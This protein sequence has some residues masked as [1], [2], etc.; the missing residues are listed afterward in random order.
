MSGE[1][2]RR[3]PAADDPPEALPLP[4]DAEPGGLEDAACPAF[5]GGVIALVYQLQA[6]FQQHRAEAQEFRQASIRDR[7]EM[8]RMLEQHCRDEQP[9]LSAIQTRLNTALALVLAVGLFALAGPEGLRQVGDAVSRGG[10]L[11]VDGLVTLAGAA[12]PL[13]YPVGRLIF[14]RLDNGRPSARPP[15]SEERT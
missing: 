7:G 15:A 2:V 1:S 12:I 6:Q 8:R 14:L 3:D 9:R 5:D 10:E 11:G 4:A 13:L